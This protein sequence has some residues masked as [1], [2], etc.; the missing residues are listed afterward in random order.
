MTV[1]VRYAPS[2]TG[3]LHIGGARTALYNYLY[4]KKMGGKFILRIEDTDLARSTRE[5]EKVVIDDMEWLGLTADEGPVTGGPHGPYRQSERL[6]IYM[7]HAKDLM[8]KG[9]AYYCF[10]TD[11]ELEKKREENLAQ[12]EELHYDGTC[13]KLNLNESKERVQKGEK[14]VIRFVAPQKDYAFN[15]LVRG[16]V[17]FPKGMIGD[18]VII[19]SNGVPVY[20]YCVVV[21]DWLMKI[22][23]V[24]RGED[25]LSNTLRQLMLYEAFGVTPPI[26]GHLSLLVGKD[27]QKLSKRHGDT[28]VTQYKV[29]TYLPS[30]MINYLTLLGWSHPQEKDIFD[31]NELISVFDIHRFSKSPAVFDLDKFRHINGEHLKRLPNEVIASELSKYIKSENP[32]HQQSFEW[33]VKAVALL[34]E[35]VSFY[36]EFNGHLEELFSNEIKLTDDLKEILSWETTPKI[37]EYLL[38]EVDALLY[39][40]KAFATKDDFEKWGNHIKI[41]LK[42]KGKNLFQGMRGV[43]TGRAHGPELKD[44][45]P[46][47]P[48][49][50]LHGRLSRD[51]S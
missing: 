49:N 2:P 13:K 19:R 45:I 14:A 8:N 20:N 40:K 42:I 11:A 22:S 30:A 27:R 43:L 28:S 47:T 33:K 16:E 50:V 35:K 10:C 4:A 34:K 1:R 25:H 3:Y 51:P 15:D 7:D 39:D 29:D 46:L 44:L 36:A 32:Y 26:F 38:K 48:L 21:D 12:G 23:H 18:F 17:K 6:D 37:K 24:L 5:Y 9:H 31:L 41:E